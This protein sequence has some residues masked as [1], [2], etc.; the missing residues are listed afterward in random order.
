MDSTTKYEV[1]VSVI[2]ELMNRS[3]RRSKDKSIDMLYDMLSVTNKDDL[4]RN[5]S[6]PFFWLRELAN[7]I[8]DEFDMEVEREREK[9]LDRHMGISDEAINDFGLVRE[10]TDVIFIEN[11]S[12]DLI[13]T[14]ICNIFELIR[15]DG[16]RGLSSISS[17]GIYE[18]SNDEQMR[19]ITGYDEYTSTLVERRY[20]SDSDVWI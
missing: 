15:D 3:D 13:N 12:T 19:Y 1:M 5:L 6:C 11:A 7:A 14:A 9:E 20:E 17:Y 16:V 4:I 18:W 2:A 10:I 8:E